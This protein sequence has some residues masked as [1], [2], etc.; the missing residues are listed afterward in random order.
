MME[1]LNIKILKSQ[2]SSLVM[3]ARS[4]NPPT[5]VNTQI[6]FG[7]FKSDSNDDGMSQHRDEL[8]AAVVNAHTRQ[9]IKIAHQ[10]KHN[11]WK[12]DGWTTL[13]G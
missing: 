4:W 8:S 1:C 11:G 5:M 10:W 13:T 3:Q 12:H 6:N 9:V 7:T 2:L